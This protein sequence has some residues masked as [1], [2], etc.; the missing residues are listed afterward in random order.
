MIVKKSED[1]SDKYYE[2]FQT[3]LHE[4]LYRVDTFLQQ[5]TCLKL[6]KIV[7]RSEI[8]STDILQDLA[9]LQQVDSKY[10]GRTDIV[11]SI[12]HTLY[13]RISYKKHVYCFPY[14]HCISKLT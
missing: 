2:E 9:L 3:S 8:N 1:V 11:K 14:M 5:D 12:K 6:Y 4:I 7:C 10:Y 13:L